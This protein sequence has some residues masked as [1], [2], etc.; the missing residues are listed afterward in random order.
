MKGSSSSSR[1]GNSV[2]LFH[3]KKNVCILRN[4]GREPPPFSED[5]DKG[6]LI[7][8]S[9]LITVRKCKDLSRCVP[10]IATLAN[11]DTCCGR[12]TTNQSLTD[13]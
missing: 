8:L 12:V 13:Q 4:L 7:P 6:L 5:H 3:I 2:S 1:N 10:K 11:A 9:H